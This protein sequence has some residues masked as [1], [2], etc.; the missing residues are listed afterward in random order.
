MYQ[1]RALERLSHDRDSKNKAPLIR[2][3]QELAAGGS[4]VCEF[5]SA[6]VRMI[7]TAKGNRPPDGASQRV[8]LS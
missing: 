1:N 6:P 8:S 4:C 5:N 2:N 7:W 3:F